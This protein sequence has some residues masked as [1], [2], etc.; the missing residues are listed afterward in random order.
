MP[1]CR[2]YLFRQV[3]SASIEFNFDGVCLVRCV[4]SALNHI[5]FSGRTRVGSENFL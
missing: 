1:G 2:L 4:M 3:G 5:G